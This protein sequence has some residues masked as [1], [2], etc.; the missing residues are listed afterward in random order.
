MTTTSQYLTELVEQKNALADILVDKGVEA[1]KEEKFNTL[2]PK[3]ADIR[4]GGGNGDLDITLITDRENFNIES[5]P[6]DITTIS[7][8]AFYGCT[9]LSLTE[10]P[11]SIQE[12]GDNAFRNCTNLSLTEL[13][14][15][16]TSIENCTFVSCKNLALTKL[17][18]TIKNV[19]YS[20]F[21]G[22]SSMP[23]NGLPNSVE[24][25][26]NYAFKSCERMTGEVLLDNIKDIPAGAFYVNGV[27]KF[28]LPSVSIVGSDAFN[29]C[30][31]CT[32]LALGKLT[33]V[34][35]TAFKSMF[36][37]EQFYIQGDSSSSLY[38]QYSTKYSANV[39]EELIRNLADLTGKTAKTLSIG[40][41]NI[42]K[43]SD[44]YIAMLEN[45]NWTLK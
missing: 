15:G 6:E 35:S 34:S 21:E 4:A 8:Y 13:P 2:I 12:I 20:A 40:E 44:E 23:L 26:G 1:S 9:N 5:L 10:L 7:P 22:C 39:L 24:S 45:K 43:L 41:T 37:L 18:D 42:A 17:P 3:V 25:I 36:N 28:N 16:I 38:L 32:Y 11:D 31:N 19:G 27:K 33:S 30:S 14:D 29:G